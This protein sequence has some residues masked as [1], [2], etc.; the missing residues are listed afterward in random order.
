[1]RRTKALVAG[2]RGS[3]SSATGWNAVVQAELAFE[4]LVRVRVRVR[5]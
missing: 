4:H 5:P 1:V 3:S 2:L